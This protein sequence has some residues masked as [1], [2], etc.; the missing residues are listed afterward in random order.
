LILVVALGASGCASWP[1]KAGGT[2]VRATPAAATDDDR[3][4][5]PEVPFATASA[6]DAIV[7]VVADG[8]ACTGTLISDDLVLTA[9]H[10]V[11]QRDRFGEVEAGEVQA[12]TVRIE[13][14]GD[15]LPWG[16]VGVRA[17]VTPPCGYR[18]GH[19]DIAVLVLDHPL[20]GAPVLEPRLDAPPQDNESVVPVGFGRC[21]HSAEGILRRVRLGG[22]IDFMAPS[23][24]RLDA[25]I[26]PG[27]SG[28]PALDDH[29]NVIGVISASVMDGD[30]K[31]RGRTEFTRLDAWRSV[32]ATAKLVAEGASVVE[33]PPIDGCSEANSAPA[34]PASR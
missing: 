21:A 26:C 34:T 15:H 9:H 24:F 19:G 6:D 25:A 27:D 2:S 10:C 28:G 5:P 8:F 32:F 11:A 17:I 13:L 7:R 1:F 31:T 14:G 18:S 30:E 33:L 4:P 23:R 3:G 22:A 12:A 16:E 29:G 20:V